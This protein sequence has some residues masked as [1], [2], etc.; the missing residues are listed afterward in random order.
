MSSQSHAVLGKKD[1]KSVMVK[2][3]KPGDALKQRKKS[4]ENQ[5][6]LVVKNLESLKEKQRNMM[7]SGQSHAQGKASVK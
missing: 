2:H 1:P 6:P 4:H 7:N 3:T 5:A